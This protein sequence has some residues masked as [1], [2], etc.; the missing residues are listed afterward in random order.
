[1]VLWHFLFVF[2][3]VHDISKPTF[4]MW[5]VSDV[6]WIIEKGLTIRL[7]I[8]ASSDIPSTV[9]LWS[10]QQWQTEDDLAWKFNKLF[11]LHRSNRS[12]WLGMLNVGLGQV[13]S[14]D[15]T[16]AIKNDLMII[17]YCRQSF[18]FRAGVTESASYMAQ[19][20]RKCVFTK[21]F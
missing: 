21:T 20:T 9:M 4:I 8:S 13:L 14:V 5:N 18:T 19:I 16:P 17:T 7:V 11:G 12:I 2:E 15:L 6:W 1:M 10:S 3:Y